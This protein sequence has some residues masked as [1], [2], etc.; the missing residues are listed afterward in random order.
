MSR[1]KFI[2]HDGTEHDVVA[3]QGSSIMEAAVSNNIPG[4]DGDCGG[5]CACATCH[6]FIDNA[7]FGK[8]EDQQ[9]DEFETAMLDMADGVEPNSRLACQLKM[10]EALDGIVIHLPDSQH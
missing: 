5:V 3:D 2:E 4:I 7:W 6:V 9:P 8:V 1:I 10:S